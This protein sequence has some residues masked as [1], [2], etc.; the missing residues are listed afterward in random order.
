MKEEKPGQ[1]F[2][3]NLAAAGA[4][5][6]VFLVVFAVA[7]IGIKQQIKEG[8]QFAFRTALYETSGVLLDPNLVQPVK[9]NVKEG[10]EFVAH[11]IKKEVRAVL[12]DPELKQDIKEAVEYTDRM[13]KTG[14][15]Q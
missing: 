13:L 8:V 7:A 11:T 12:Q 5:G 6:L 1:I 3:R 15:V 14:S 2:I 9:K 10:I 4:W